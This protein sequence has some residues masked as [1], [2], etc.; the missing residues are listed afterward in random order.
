MN[1]LNITAVSIC[2]VTMLFAIQ[3]HALGGTITYSWT[4]RIVPEFVN[5]DPWAIGPGKPFSISVTLSDNSED[6]DPKVDGAAFDALKVV[7]LIDGELP[8]SI[9]DDFFGI[10]GIG[11]HDFASRD[12][13]SIGLNNVQFNGV[14]EASF[15]TRVRLP[16]ST[17][18]LTNVV[19]FP[20]LFP[21]T[22]TITR[23]SGTGVGSSY[24]TIT[25]VGVLVTATR[26]PEPS[27]FLL[28]LLA[29]SVLGTRVFWRKFD[30]AR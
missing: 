12:D 3:G 5:L 8:T 19:E 6:V 1:R 16:V 24:R 26:I 27:T 20:P 23:N 21:P 4:G 17:F 28:A 29:L 7:F 15:R 10:G 11:F 22:R 13:I 30:R 14:T 9:G 25:E 18:N 2:L